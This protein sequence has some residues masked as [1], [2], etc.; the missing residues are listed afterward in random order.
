M[1]FHGGRRRARWWCYLLVARRPGGAGWPAARPR[2]RSRPL[3]PHLGPNGPTTARPRCLLCG[4]VEERLGQGA[5]TPTAS[6]LQ[7]EGGS[8]T[9]PRAWYAPAIASGRLPS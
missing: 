6:L 4:D 2:P 9:G 8:F 5:A 3:G 1:L 7:R